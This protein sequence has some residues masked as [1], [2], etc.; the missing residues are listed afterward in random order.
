MDQ[1]ALHTE[2]LTLVPLAE[3]RLAL[4]VALD[5]DPEAD[6]GFRLLRSRWRRGYAVDGAR[7]LIRYGFAD[8]GLDRVFARTS[9]SNT[10]SRATISGV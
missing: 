2:R 5:A 8:L 4:A 3:E 7:E 9:A 1:P 6:L 10:A